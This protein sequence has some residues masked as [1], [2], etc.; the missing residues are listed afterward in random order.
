MH[1]LKSGA[2]LFGLRKISLMYE[3]QQKLDLN[4]RSENPNNDAMILN[5]LSQDG[6]YVDDPEVHSKFTDVNIQKF[7]E[8][9]LSAMPDRADSNEKH[10]Y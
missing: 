6:I 8:R 9:L 4:Y 2:G 1:H 7:E 10:H 3:K 5:Q